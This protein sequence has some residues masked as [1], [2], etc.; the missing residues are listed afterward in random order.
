MPLSGAQNGMHP[1][2]AHSQ[3]TPTVAVSRSNF[4]HVAAILSSAILAIGDAGTV[5]AD[6]LDSPSFQYT[7]PAPASDEYTMVR[8]Q[9]IYGL[10]SQY[11]SDGYARPLRTRMAMEECA[12]GKFASGVTTLNDAL[13]RAKVLHP[14]MASTTATG[15]AN[16][17]AAQAPLDPRTL[18][19]Q[20]T[21]YYDRYGVGRDENSD[22]VCNHTRIGADIDCQ[23]GQYDKG[24]AVMAVLLKSKKFDVPRLPTAVAQP[25][26]R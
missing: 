3:P 1:M 15:T 13:D 5:S 8:C 24:I 20:L 6:S 25:A 10:H 16:S 26:L 23:R 11:N 18:C 9:Q 14:T 19:E 17:A 22:G 4:R 2:M 12:K 7:P 21:S